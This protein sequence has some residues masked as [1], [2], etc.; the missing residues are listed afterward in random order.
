MNRRAFLKTLTALGASTAA[1]R[2]LANDYTIT[3]RPVGFRE[4]REAV[5]ARAVLLDQ[6]QYVRPAVL[7]KV[8][9]VFLYGGPS[10]LAG[11]L[12]NIAD[13]NHYSQ[14]PYPATLQPNVS[15][16]VYTRNG[17]WGNAGGNVME[18]M[19]AAGDLSVYRTI[20]RVRDD[21]K[22]H[23]RSITQNLVGSVDTGN[24]GIARTLAGVLAAHGAFGA[25]DLNTLFLPFVSFEGQ[26]RIYGEGDTPTLIPSAVMPIALDPD[27]V[28]NPYQRAANSFLPANSADDATLEA[29]AASVTAAYGDRYTE[30]SRSLVN[31]ARLDQYVLTQFNRI[32][33]D[34][35]LPAGVLYANTRLGR[36]LKAAVS[37]ALMNPDTLFI[38]IN[39]AGPGWDDHNVALTNYPARMS[40]LMSALS[41]AMTHLRA[42]NRN[43]IIINVYGDFGRNVNLNDT[44]GWDHGNNQ[45]FYTLGGADIAGRQ[46]GKLVGKT[47]LIGTAYA[48]RQYTSPAAD[49]YQCEPFAIAASLFKYFGIQNPEVLTGGVSAIDE[50]NPP[51][52]RS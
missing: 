44:L 7:P 20:N 2:A 17:F 12:T 14:N 40:D 26:S 24:P 49:S 31:R 34:A 6:V 33:V 23:G 18:S 29:L 13:I 25:R 11:N 30:M 38:S 37:L 4:S 1:L 46:L 16:S 9:N 41:A 22:A 28:G 8:I 10:E 45:N 42:S 48:N 50:I 36:A 47:Q 35:A 52:L 15:G 39:G 32:T 51:N 21:N 19:L 43:D 27:L 3:S 5:E